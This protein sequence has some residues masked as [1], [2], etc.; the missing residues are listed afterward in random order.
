M[1]LH[2]G[3]GGGKYSRDDKRFRELRTALE[4]GLSA[5]KRGSSIDGVEAAVSYMEKCGA[6][7]AGRG[8]CMTAEGT[9]QLDAA[10]M[11][12]RGRKGG[13]VGVV[14]CTYNPIALARWVMENT[15]HVLIV[16]E[17]C[18]S[19]ARAARLT[20]EPISPSIESEIRFAK[21]RTSEGAPNLELWKRIQDG[22]TVGAVAVD[23]SGV[24]SAAVSTGG[25]WMKL[26]GRVGDS[27]IIGAGI[28][29]DAGLGAACAT[30][31]GEEIIRNAL[32]W[33]ACEYMRSAD[34]GRAARRAIDLM[35]RRSGAATCG[36][37]TVDRKGRVG[38]DFNTEAMGVAWSDANG[39]VHVRD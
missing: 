25:M 38:F 24:P 12:G 2:G 9:L 19:I 34:A 35:T 21:L 4:E 27:A 26:P 7:N 30:G 22:G 14:A 36:I 15:H 29:A 23:S 39:R 5:M 10:I 18:E 1:I 8:A 17:A 13:G 33:N 16:G 28:Y 11:E 32:S 6:F 3:A 31:T 37:I 20:V